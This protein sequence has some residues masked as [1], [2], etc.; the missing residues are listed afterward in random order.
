MGDTILTSALVGAIVGAAVV[1]I[2]G[3]MSNRRKG[4]F[5]VKVNRSGVVDTPLP[6]AEA[7]Q[8]I[9]ASAADHGLKVE[10][11]DTPGQRIL[12]SE[13]MGLASFGHFFP[14]SVAP[15][16]GG[17]SAVTVGL[18]TKVP[19]YGP[20]VGRNHRKIM[21]KIRSAVSAT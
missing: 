11:V 18:K 14:I 20:V 5:D 21:N 15:A 9:E 2:F 8:R 4:S 16:D 7:L 12:L 1:L 19:Q 13:G 6:P 17:G 10:Q 3:L